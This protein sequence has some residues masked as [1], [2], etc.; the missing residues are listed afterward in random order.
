MQK[1]RLYP[2]G[3]EEWYT[4]DQLAA[5][6]ESSGLTVIRR[7]SILFLPWFL[8]FMD[9]FVWLN[10][11]RLSRIMGLIVE[12]FRKLSRSESFFRKFGYLTVCVAQKS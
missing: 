7:D 4:N 6:L 8:R 5:K 9:L 11:P 3:Y 10:A 1:L 12:P 2:Y